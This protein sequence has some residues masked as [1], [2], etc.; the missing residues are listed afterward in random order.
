MKVALIVPGGVD[1][2]GEVRVIP[3]LLW[4][5]ERLAKLH[6]VHVF[7]LYQLPT[8]SRYELCGA[9]VHAIG[10]SWTRVRAMQA[11]IAEH[12]QAPFGVFHAFWASPA[13]VLAV[14]LG[15][16]LRRPT[17]LHLSGGELTSH[18]EIDYGGSRRFRGRLMVRIA[19]LGSTRVT[20]ASAI[21]RD[22][23]AL[24]GREVERLP[25]G[26][27]LGSWPV[28]APRRRCAT[29][30]A[31]LVHV[32]SLNRVKD[33]RTLLH[34]ARFL[35]DRGLDFHLDVIGEDTLNGEVQRHARTLGLTKH[36]TFHGFLRHARLRPYVERADLMIVSSV[37]EAGPLV[38]SEAAVAG[39]PVVGTAVGQILDWAPDAA[40]SVPVG[41]H[42]ALASEVLALLADEGRRIA[43]ATEAQRRAVCEDADWTAKRCDALYRELV[44]PSEVQ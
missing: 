18:P 36:V 5:L 41:D 42:Q 20:A 4:L 39:V 7:A 27:D 11:A 44:G 19:L 43:I 3:A 25:L 28:R 15:R 33:Q 21:V 6:E 29:D 37:H 17:L 8:R 24:R 32:A 23:A 14:A 13:G 35:R 31:R 40:V 1:A 34:A 12:R 10:R 16:L 38:L 22:Q 26:V 9:T 2:S 30:P